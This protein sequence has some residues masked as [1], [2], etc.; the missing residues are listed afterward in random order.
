MLNTVDVEVAQRGL[1]ADRDRVARPVPGWSHRCPE[2][3]EADV[4]DTSLPRAGETA[5]DFSRPVPHR[6]SKRWS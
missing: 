3:L 6:D 4:H 5:A 2:P 1:P